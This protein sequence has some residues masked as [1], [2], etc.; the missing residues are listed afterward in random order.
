MLKN[1]GRWPSKLLF[2][3]AAA[4]PL[5][6]VI[7]EA[8]AVESHSGIA[9]SKTPLVGFAQDNMTGAWPRCRGASALLSAI[10]L[11]TTPTKWV[12]L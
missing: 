3:L 11:S 10:Q 5:L 8:Q 1:I 12:S 7:E 4:L 2:L 6:G 9:I